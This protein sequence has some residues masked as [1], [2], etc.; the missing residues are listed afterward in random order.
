MLVNCEVFWCSCCTK[1]NEPT[2]NR[3]MYDRKQSFSAQFSAELCLCE[4]KI[5][6]P[7][8]GLHA[9]PTHLPIL[10]FQPSW[11]PSVAP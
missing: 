6:M 8:H 7:F 5:G 3:L 9:F 1:D 4:A 11:W 10:W 2:S